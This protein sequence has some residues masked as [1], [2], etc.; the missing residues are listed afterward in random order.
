MT[1]TTNPNPNLYALLIGID[2]Y[3]PNRLSNGVSYRN[4]GGSVRDINHVEEFLLRQPKKPTQIF[5]LTSSNPDFTEFGEFPQPK[6]PESQL[7]TYKNIVAKF[8]ELTQTASSGDLVYIQYSGH[9]GRAITHYPQI[10]GENSIDEGLVPV[11]IGT[12]K[13][14]YLRDLELAMLM[15]KM[16]DKGLVVT[17]VMDCCHSGG[18][19]RGEYADIRGLDT[20]DET[21]RPVSNLVASTEELAQHWQSL[22]QEQP[23]TS[24]AVSRKGTAVAGMLPEVEGYVCLTACRPSE[25]AFEY[26]FDSKRRNGALTYWLLDTLNQPMPGMTY[27]VLHDRINAK[28]KTLFPQQTPMLMG[29][30][31]RLIFGSEY[32]QTEYAVKIMEVRVEGNITKVKLDAGQ[33]QGL[34]KGAELAIYSFGSRNFQEVNE[35]IAIAEITELGASD[36]WAEVKNIL[37][38]TSVIEQGAQAVLTSAPVKLV[39][40]VRLLKDENINKNIPLQAVESALIGNGWVELAKEDE[41]ADFMVDVDESIYQMYDRTGSQIVLRPLLKVNEFDSAEILVKRL[42]HLAKYQSIQ[43]LDNHD[44]NSPLRGKIAVELLGTQADYDPADLPDIKSLTDHSQ[45]EVKS[46]EYFFF[47]IRNDYSDVVNVAVLDLQPDWGIEQVQPINSQF[48]SLDPGGEEMVTLNMTLPSG[49]QIGEDIF[50]VFATVGMANFRWLELPPLDQP[51]LPPEAKGVS[52][53]GSGLD[54]FLIT[55]AAEQPPTRNGNPVAFPSREWTTTQFQV[56]VKGDGENKQVG[57]IDPVDNPNPN[58]QLS[59]NPTTPN[60][61]SPTY[62]YSSKKLT[63]ILILA[64]NPRQDLR[65]ASE[66][67]D[68]REIIRSSPNREQFQLEQREA[69]R[70][71]DLQRALLEVEPRIVHF[72]GHGSGNQGLVL[73]N[74][75]GE[76][77][78]VTTEAISNLFKQ[79]Q[80]Q[81]ECVL[82]NACSSQTQAHSIVQHI[83]YVI[84]MGRDILDDAAIAFT[85]GFYEALVHGR[86]IDSAYEFGRDRI[87]IEINRSKNYRTPNPV[88]VPEHLIPK[89]LK[90]PNPVEIY[91]PV[92]EKL[93]IPSPGNNN[94][95]NK[96]GIQQVISGGKMTGGMQASIGDGNQQSMQIGSNKSHEKELSVE[97]VIQ[98][99]EQ[100]EQLIS[101]AELAVDVKRKLLRYLESAKDAVLEAE[102]DKKYAAFSL[103][104]MVDTLRNGGEISN[105]SLCRNVEVI[106]EELNSWFG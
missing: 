62:S 74:N 51:I 80:N 1:K 37:D 57:S 48:I 78:L 47:K 106:L 49:E 63:K 46:G 27:K 14:Q 53:S 101:A 16:V 98:K 44:A 75:A 43:E 56:K 17:L 66:I 40:K 91:S 73:E 105:Q 72:C 95:T 31:E 102:P 12:G 82:L 76:Q 71:Q 7:P 54:D 5:K 23:N 97:E 36:S 20:I 25:Y 52:R 10:K 24:G 83:N 68:I 88:A 6:E 4:L 81:V 39:K 104:K 64:A 9:G 67:R 55:F 84:G 103:K 38:N 58:Q 77:R 90:N 50:K 89:L 94:Q 42:I 79:F 41:A 32:V 93:E 59:S 18:T 85:K 96:G 15:K 28:I 70:P 29:E 2:C 87:Q 69:L 22:T 33:A 21:Q 26:A 11:D 65:L 34:R 99:L 61:P 86:T 30:G 19:V 8:Q 92:E 45:P 60:H 100:I 13:G 35:R 3:L